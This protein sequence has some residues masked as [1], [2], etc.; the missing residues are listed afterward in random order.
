MVG[1]KKDTF[2]LSFQ[3]TWFTKGDLIKEDGKYK[4][5]VIDTPKYHYFKWYYKILYYLTFTLLFE[6]KITY[7]VKILNYEKRKNS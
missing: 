2:K 7:A 3:E 6:P 5:K 1:L 4:C